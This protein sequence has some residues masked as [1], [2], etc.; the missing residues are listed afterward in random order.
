M[1]FLTRVKDIV[2]ITLSTKSGFILFKNLNIIVVDTITSDLP[3]WNI[4][5]ELNNKIKI[6]T[7]S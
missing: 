3:K 1:V 2:S 5:S 7:T 6:F 4:T